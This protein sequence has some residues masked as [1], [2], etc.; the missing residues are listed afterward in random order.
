MS[1][2]DWI[3]RAEAALAASGHK[4]GGARSALLQ[5]LAAQTCVLSVA[6][7][8]HAQND[9]GRR[10]VSRASIYRILDELEQLQLV[11]RVEVGQ[12]MVRYERARPAEEHHHHLVCVSCGR[13]TPFSD[14]GLERAIERLSKAI[15]LTVAE[16]EIVLRGACRDCGA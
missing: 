3:G 16:H 11:Q 6:D 9:P 1:G 12:G 15:P 4:R 2:E 10:S 14:A 5:L 7:I 8:E 13:V